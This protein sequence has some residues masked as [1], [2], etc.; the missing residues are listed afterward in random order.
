MVVHLLHAVFVPGKYED[1]LPFEVLYLSQQVIK[2]THTT[3]IVFVEQLI[4]F[5]DKQNTTSDL[6]DSVQNC[7]AS[8]YSTR[9]Q[10]RTTDL[11][12]GPLRTSGINVLIMQKVGIDPDN[13]CFACDKLK[14]RKYKVT[15]GELTSSWTTRKDGTEMLLL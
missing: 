13:A 9:G 10:G 1:N 12:K 3:V 4:G 5:V 8:C 2:H 11:L 7:L 15:E 6:F 14:T